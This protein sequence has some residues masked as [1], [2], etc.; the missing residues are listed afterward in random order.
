MKIILSYPPTYYDTL[1]VDAV[2]STRPRPRVMFTMTAP[3][4]SSADT[5]E[6]DAVWAALVRM[7]KAVLD[8]DQ[9]RKDQ[10]VGC[11]SGRVMGVVP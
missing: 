5:D 3:V 9:R 2:V 7:A 1:H 6:V 4:V 10:R 8:E 11:P